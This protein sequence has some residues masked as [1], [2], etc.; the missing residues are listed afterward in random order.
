MFP[1]ECGVVGER[2]QQVDL[3]PV[4]G[5]G[6]G[7]MHQ[8]DH[9][10]CM[11]TDDRNRQYRAEAFVIGEGLHWLPRTEQFLHRFAGAE[12]QH[13]SRTHVL[14][15]QG[16]PLVIA[17]TMAVANLHAQHSLLVW[18]EHTCSLHINQPLHLANDLS[19]YSMWFK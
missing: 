18:E 2:Q 9:A 19:Y 16:E 3:V 6:L 5:M 11:S 1:G 15:R 13:R 8:Q 4:E 14:R 17:F 7:A 12:R 10:S